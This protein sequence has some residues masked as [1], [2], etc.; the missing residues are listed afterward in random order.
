M[1]QKAIQ[2][3][4]TLKKI[5]QKQ[6]PDCIIHDPH[7][8]NDEAREYIEDCLAQHDWKLFTRDEIEKMIIDLAVI[9]YGRYDPDKSKQRNRYIFHPLGYD[10]NP[11]H[12][13]KNRSSY[14]LYQIIPYVKEPSKNSA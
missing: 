9:R 2:N 6:F 11:P 5:F 13:N 7:S 3:P 14:N 1:F 10:C 8:S 4:P 12:K